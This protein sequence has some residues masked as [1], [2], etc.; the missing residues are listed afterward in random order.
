MLLSKDL[1]EEETKAP[2]V[3]NGS[4]L[5]LLSWVWLGMLLE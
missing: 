4:H 3:G 1:R 5:L 2:T